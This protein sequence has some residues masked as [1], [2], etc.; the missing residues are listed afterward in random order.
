MSST[1]LVP[2]KF[3]VL[4]A[5]H[6]RLFRFAKEIGQVVIAGLD[7]N[8]LNQ[9]E[10]N[11]R[12]DAL[13]SLEFVDQVETFEGSIVNLVLRLKP[14]IVLKGRE[15]EGQENI[16]SK[17]VNNYG[18]KLVFSSGTSYYLGE[19][20]DEYY[21][22][23]LD[24]DIH[25]SGKDYISRNKID[26][27]SILSIV[28][29]FK[30]LRTCVIGDL[31]IDEI[32]NCH[33]VGMSQEDPTIVAT[34]IE[35][36]KFIG[37]AGIVSGHCNA[38]GSK[39]TFV[40]V[41]GNDDLSDWSKSQFDKASPRL[42]SFN[43][44][45]RKTTLKQRFKSGKQVL[46]KLNHFT[47]D[48]IENS[49]ENAIL[50][51]F[52][53]EIMN[54]DLIILSDFSYGVVTNRISREIICLAKSLNIPV[55][56]DSQT[57]SQV[58][59]LSRFVGAKLVTPTE[60]EA[61]NEIRD[62]SSGLAVVAQKIRALLEIEY[63]LVKLGADGVLL[64]GIDEQGKIIRTD[65]VPALNKNP[66]DVSGAGDSMLAGTALTL[67]SGYSIYIAAYIG[68]IMSAIQVSRSGNIPI[69]KDEFKSLFV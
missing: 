33:P 16:E 14:E 44:S 36:R 6:I 32:I 60:L 55:M 20:F 47:Q 13:S 51:F 40:T 9:S 10:I 35:S 49:T 28:D 66:V 54:F 19:D 39:T 11:W 37:G 12:K 18:G 62:E 45:Y 63:V 1:V 61:R 46:F 21:V 27:E 48:P 17:I 29:N 64:A 69:S 23:R 50:E 30:N 25:N 8:G 52:K 2:G 7:I 4:H 57:S 26:K 22:N 24:Q 59:N 38:L 42:V 3:V 43:E 5:G 68:S 56:A 58:G 31:I 53:R 41:L 15:F 65:L 34:P 67:A